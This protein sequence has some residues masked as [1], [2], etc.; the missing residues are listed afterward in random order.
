MGENPRVYC[1]RD[2]TLGNVAPSG[3]VLRLCPLGTYHVG[4]AY[5][6]LFFLSFLP[7]FH[8]PEET[9]TDEARAEGQAADEKKEPKV[10]RERPGSG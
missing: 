10:Q 3:P 4:G 7:F 9:G 8:G 1:P 2:V 6:H 5:R